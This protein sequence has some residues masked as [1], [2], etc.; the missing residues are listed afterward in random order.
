MTHLFTNI[1][2]HK[3]DEEEYPDQDTEKG[4]YSCLFG[5]VSLE[6]GRIFLFS[7][8]IEKTW[9]DKSNAAYTDGWDVLK[10]YAYI[11]EY[12]CSKNLS[13]E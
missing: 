3:E 7:H 10:Y 11:L 4:D 9:N 13:S 12:D 5:L 2:S 6:G 8:D 1:Y